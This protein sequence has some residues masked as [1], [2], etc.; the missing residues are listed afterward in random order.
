MGPGFRGALRRL[1]GPEGVSQ[2]S[3]GHCCERGAPFPASVERSPSEPSGL[4][5]QSRDSGALRERGGHR[6]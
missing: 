2:L 3:E 4:W 1:W 6:F 5:Q